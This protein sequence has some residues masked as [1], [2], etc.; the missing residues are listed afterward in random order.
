MKKVVPN[1]VSRKN[2][3]SEINDQRI[4]LKELAIAHEFQIVNEYL[5]LTRNRT[6]PFQIDFQDICFIYRK[7]N[8]I[9]SIILVTHKLI[10]KSCK[11]VNSLTAF[12]LCL[13]AAHFSNSNFLALLYPKAI[14]DRTV[15]S[16]TRKNT[17][18]LFKSI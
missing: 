4:K 12:N 13:S 10:T 3:A 1:A 7:W 15:N 6:I 5:Q 8:T 11:A 14:S 9:L 16:I 2:Q 17:S 18:F